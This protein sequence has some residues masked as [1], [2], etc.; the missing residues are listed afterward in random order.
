MVAAHYAEAART[1]GFDYVVSG[2]PP[3]SRGARSRA[4]TASKASRHALLHNLKKRP[5]RVSKIARGPAD[6]T[7][8]GLALITDATG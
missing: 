1:G 8:C 3:L 7:D 5:E 2:A 4:R 6:A